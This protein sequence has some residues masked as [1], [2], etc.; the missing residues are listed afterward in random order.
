MPRR[1]DHA[2]SRMYISK[3]DYASLRKPL[4]SRDLLSAFTFCLS[5]LPPRQFPRAASPPRPFLFFFQDEKCSIDCATSPFLYLRAA[6]EG[7]LTTDTVSS[8]I[9]EASTPRNGRPYSRQSI[10]WGTHALSTLS[11]YLPEMTETSAT[12]PPGNGANTLK[13]LEDSNRTWFNN[14]RCEFTRCS[15]L[16]LTLHSKHSLIALHGWIVLLLITSY[17]SGYDGSM[18]NGLQSLPQWE[19]YFNFPTKG[20]LGL[21]GAIQNIGSLAGYPFAPYLCDG[22]GRRPTVFIGALI[23]SLAT[24]IQTASQSVGMFIGARAAPM[25]IAELS[26]PKYRAP[27]TS[28]YN[29]LWHSGSVVAAWTTFGSFHIQSTWAWRLPSALQALPSI[30]QVLLVYLVPE[31]PRYLIKKGKEA[32]GLKILAYYH[33]DGNE[34]DPLVRYEFEEIKAAME[35]DRTV[36]ANVGWK[37]LISSKGNLKRLRII[38][39]IAFFSQWSGNGLAG[40][41]LNKVLS[42]IG[43][44][45]PTTQLLLNGILSIWSLI[46]GLTTSSIVERFGRR[47]LFLSSA[48]LMTLFFTMQTASFARF[49]INGDPNAAHAVIAFIFLY[50]AAYNLAFSPLIVTYALEILPYN[51]RAKGFNVFNITISIA[52]IFN[53]YVNPIALAALTWKYYIVYCVWLVCECV[54]LWFY[55]VETKNHTLEETAAIFDGMGASE[56][57]AGDAAAHAGVGGA[58]PESKRSDE[59]GSTEY[60]TVA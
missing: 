10:S 1:S 57:I 47:L 52:L 19:R 14:R 60:V 49:T 8:K 54:F 21:L 28:V 22:I 25:L 15:L 42:D 39:A 38:I 45:N 48:F 9:N 33:A 35:Y 16:S 36:V 13:D 59:K 17:A 24:V 41:Y 6:R 11:I 4:Y 7:Q 18:V 50:S 3:T 26:Y 53:Q 5:C 29:S 27:L 20:K 55:L 58:E 30:L 34:K 46:C 32:Q 2:G 56:K 31:S 40:Y 51:I 44:T 37:S 12:A 23:M 43:I